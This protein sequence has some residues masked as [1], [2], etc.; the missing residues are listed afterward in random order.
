[1]SWQRAEARVVA[2]SRLKV[3]GGFATVRSCVQVEDLHP[4][5]AVLVAHDVGVVGV[6]LELAPRGRAGVRRQVA[7]VDGVR[8]V[9]DV[10]ER[11]AV[12]AA[13]QRVLLLV[14]GSVQPQMSLRVA[15]R[16]SAALGRKAIRSTLSQG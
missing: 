3:T 15:R 6:G 5:G 9:G 7:Q 12:G 1:M 16:R 8:G 10:H 11:R 13:E 2:R 14:S 4:V